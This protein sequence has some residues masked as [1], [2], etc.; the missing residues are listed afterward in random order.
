VSFVFSIAHEEGS[1]KINVYYRGEL[2]AG[3]A[4][5]SETARMVPLDALP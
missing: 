3:P 1:G 2:G 4:P 5:D